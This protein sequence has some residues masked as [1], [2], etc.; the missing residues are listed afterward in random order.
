MTL[1][2]LDLT[3]LYTACKILVDNCK[4]KEEQDRKVMDF[5]TFDVTY[6]APKRLINNFF[7]YNTIFPI[8]FKDVPYDDM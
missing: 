3:L 5:E 4:E 7:R 6:N 1:Q 2:E 8:P